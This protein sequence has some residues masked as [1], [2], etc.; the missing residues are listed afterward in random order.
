MP[1]IYIIKIPGWRTFSLEIPAFRQIIDSAIGR[2]KQVFRSPIFAAI[3]QGHDDKALRLAT[4]RRLHGARGKWGETPL[5]AAIAADRQDL[6]LALIRRGGTFA[7]DGALAHAAMRGNLQIVQSLLA[8]G[9]SPDEPLN[10][11]DGGVTP[12]MWATNRKFYA[13]MESLLAAGANINAQ[14]KNGTTAAMYTR[15]GTPEF[16]TALDVLCRYK[17]NISLQDWRGRNLKKE[18]NDRERNS[19]DPAMRILLERHFPEVDFQDE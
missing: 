4:S 13:C 10:N 2:S 1:S 15:S 8:T 3:E 11:G 18:A 19:N 16:L 6:A 12:L 9:K 14:D 7:G 17:P 5:V